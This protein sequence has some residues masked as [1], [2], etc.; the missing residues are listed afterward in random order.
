MKSEDLFLAIGSVE[1]SRLARSELCVSSDKKQEDKTVNGK[2]A[3]TVRN[4]LVA[5]M[6]V[7]MLAVAAY[8][9]GGLL[10]FESPK[11]MLAAI[12]GDSTGFDHAAKGD[13][14]DRY[15]NVLV[16]HPGFHRVPVDETVVSDDVAPYV[17]MVGKS[18]SS[19]GYTLTVDAFMYDEATK[20]GFFTYLLENPN[21]V[22]GYRL[23]STGEIWYEGGPNMVQV[24]E[25]GYP[26]I[27][28]DK[29]TDTCLAA[30]YYFRD[31]G[32][33]GDDLVISLPSEEKPLT[34][35]EI[36]KIVARLDKEIRQKFTPEEAIEQTKELIGEAIFAV[37]SGIPDGVD[38]TQEEWDAERAYTILRDEW[39][40][41]EYERKGASISIPMAGTSLNHATALNGSVVI[42]PISFQLDATGLDDI[43]PDIVQDDNMAVVSRLTICF[44]DGT[45]YV[46]QNDQLDNTIYKLADSATEGEMDLY[47]RYTCMF[48][49]IIDVD[50]VTA[51]MIDGNRVAVD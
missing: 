29:T 25:Y 26:Y 42:S 23:Q 44:K 13:I 28:Q 10:I 22:T 51:V 40:H 20:C 45:E 17:N 39:Y 18:V 9:V 21:G 7:S 37:G 14:I 35:E 4:L 47:N 16:E 48:N 34:D 27:I 32:L 46:V 30:T 38:M 19:S 50:N 15:E 11:E 41:E 31:T 3:R 1:E 33:R 43:L 2:L 8:A 49:R 5:V 6:I 24:N 36:N 12:F